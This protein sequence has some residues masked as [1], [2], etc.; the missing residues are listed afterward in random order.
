MRRYALRDDQW[1]RIKDQLPGR[2]GW[3]GMTAA[4]NR[5]FVEAVIRAGAALHADDTTVPVL[6]PGLGRTKTG[7][8]WVLVRDERPWG[9]PSPPAAFYRYSA[10]RK[11]VH[12][13]ALLA[14]CRG[15]LHADGYAGFD[16]LYAPT[17]PV[18]APAL[19]EVA[20]WSH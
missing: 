10:D 3:V 15:F 17:T 14:S 13:E 9:S 11:G 20:C 4:D 12:A 8:L 7:R 2:D 19:I 18:G 16:K 6:S 1:D 5:L